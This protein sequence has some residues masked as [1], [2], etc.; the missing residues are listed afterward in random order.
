MRFVSDRNI[1]LV[2][3]IKNVITVE[4]YC[5]WYSLYFINENGEVKKLDDV[6]PEA[7]QIIFCDNA[8][9]P[10]SVVEFA[11]KNNLSLGLYSF[12]ALIDRY[13]EATDNNIFSDDYLPPRDLFDSVIV[14]DYGDIYKC[15]FDTSHLS[16]YD[17][18]GKE[19]AKIPNIDN[20]LPFKLF[21]N[22]MIRDYNNDIKNIEKELLH[23]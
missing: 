3:T 23:E 18:S 2:S 5:K 4:N 20:S 21:K 1:E 11:N 10:A 6:F 9:E 7:E 22:D 13:I 19:V 14:N 17:I 15:C 16:Y 12:I 8:W